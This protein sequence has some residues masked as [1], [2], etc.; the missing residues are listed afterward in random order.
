MGCCSKTFRAIIAL[1]LSSVANAAMAQ[2]GG[3]LFNSRDVASP[4]RDRHLRTWIASD[5]PASNPF[6]HRLLSKT[7]D[8]LLVSVSPIRAGADD[9]TC[10]AI[11]FSKSVEK[12]TSIDSPA[13]LTAPSL[14]GA[15][16]FETTTFS[17]LENSSLEKIDSGR[18]LG[19]ITSNMLIIKRIGA[20][21]QLLPD[22]RVEPNPFVETN[23]RGWRIDPLSK[24]L[25]DDGPLNRLSESTRL[26]KS[27]RL[28]EPEAEIE[29][30][31]N[32][33]SVSP[34]SS[35]LDYLNCKMKD[36][37][38]AVAKFAT[39]TSFASNVATEDA[40][41]VFIKGITT[42]PIV[43]ELATPHVFA[44]AQSSLWKRGWFVAAVT[45]GALALYQFRTC[46]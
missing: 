4:V 39:G 21:D 46:D 23:E 11:P 42:S 38:S 41:K 36:K 33:S 8:Q 20:P 13:A 17:S 30:R 1:S 2:D 28:D 43:A 7:C 12:F 6:I 14:V 26:F 3:S 25:D 9:T 16:P 29:S 45:T 27:R 10:V 40:T 24:R 34:T 44:V 5:N 18:Q 15:T 32:P 37:I 31:F 19:N 22:H 35:W